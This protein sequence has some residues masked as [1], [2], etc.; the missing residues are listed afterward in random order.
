ML[1][2]LGL[3]CMCNA[4]RHVPAL[5]QHHAAPNAQARELEDAEE[6]LLH[7]KAK[8]QPKPAEQQRGA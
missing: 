3:F 4:L 5:T 6:E 8:P 7:G 2:K 1:L